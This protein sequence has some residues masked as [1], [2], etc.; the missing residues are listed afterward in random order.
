MEI[1]QK[2]KSIDSF[3]QKTSRNDYFDWPLAK[4]I[5]NNKT[6]SV[7]LSKCGKIENFSTESLGIHFVKNKKQANFHS[8][9]GFLNFEKKVSVWQT[10]RNRRLIHQAILEKYGDTREYLQ[11]VFVDSF[12]EM[13][14]V[15]MWNVSIVGALIFGMFIM[16]SIYRYL[17]Q[18]A[19][20]G[21]LQASSKSAIET[22]VAGEQAGE[23]LGA[24]T[25][26]EVGEKDTK[27]TEDYVSKIIK[28]YEE[29]SKGSQKMEDEIRKMV[30]G[31]PIEKMVSFIAKEDKVVAA[32]LVSI[33]KKESN[34]GKRSP[35]LKGQ[36][37]YNYWGYRG[38]R[39]KMG[40]GGHTC[41][42]SPKDA[43]ETVAKRLSFLVSSEKMTTPAKMVVWK[44]G[45]DCSWDNPAA[46]RKW[47]NDVEHYFKKFDKV[48]S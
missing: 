17:G 9:D 6:S 42:D 21:Q 36:D 27:E 10:F 15:K 14:L 19:S 44:C 3:C 31:Y 41:F 48:N 11:N 5:K 38:K 43:V 22:L 47:I 35:V 34:W 18:D 1:F 8:L 25:E 24:E 30:K 7:L 12:R 39:K 28:D 20:A 16:T 33:A 4:F 29:E 40:S 23:V 32:F 2:Q 45:Y 46:V 37:C 26:K 13:S